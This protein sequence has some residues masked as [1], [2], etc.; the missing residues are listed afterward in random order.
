M[1]LQRALHD[2]S[3]RRP[4]PP[5]RHVGLRA[6]ARQRA[7]RYVFCLTRCACRHYNSA[8]DDSACARWRAMLATPWLTALL[9]ERRWLEG[10]RRHRARL[11]AE[12]QCLLIAREE[13]RN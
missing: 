8:H 10:L 11:S 13:E 9:L 7:R 6:I 12:R 4:A 5:D 2:N 3:P 1:P